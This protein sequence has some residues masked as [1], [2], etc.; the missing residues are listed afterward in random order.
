MLHIQKIHPFPE[1][2]QLSLPVDSTKGSKHFSRI[3][4][5][6]SNHPG[7]RS[8]RAHTRKSEAASK[9]DAALFAGLEED[10]P[11]KDE[12]RKCELH[13]YERRFNTR[14]EPIL[15][16]SGRKTELGGETGS[17]A[18]AALVLIRFYDISRKLISTK[19]DILS[20]HIK[21]TLREVVRSYPRVNIKSSGPISIFDKPRCL[22]H[23]RSELEAHASMLQDP[24]AKDHVAFCL[25]YMA[26]TLRREILGYQN[27]MQ[28]KEVIPGL[29]YQ[30]LWMAFKP[31]ALLY[32]SFEDIDVIC[33][34]RAMHE[35]THDLLPFW[36][37]KTEV[38]M[39][40]GK[41]LEYIHHD[42]RISHYD[43]YKPLQ[44][45]EIFPL[46][47][48]QQQESI[49]ASLLQRGEKYVSLRGIHHCSYEGLADI[50]SS[51]DTGSKSSMVC[52]YI[53]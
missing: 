41:R 9:E 34:L 16:Q 27:T 33:R 8:T 2:K 22:F 21:A 19:L 38:L 15:L 23:Y 37:V 46:E 40:W 11:Y 51:H 25:R 50:T 44:E 20:P 49:K 3:N 13:T 35:M 53:E 47:Y 14:G 24:V 43:G 52:L 30:D 36:N 6:S 4:M 39:C 29:E 10:H 45:L 7:L 18:E 28:D 12:G 5:R 48:H 26:K 17:S 1:F 42:V 32:Q 31:G